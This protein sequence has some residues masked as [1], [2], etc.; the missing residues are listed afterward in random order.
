M[1]R[2]IIRD[3]FV[4]SKKSKNATKDDLP[5]AID[6]RDTLLANKTRAL[7]IAANMIGVNKNI[8]AFFIGPLPIVM[9]NPVI[10]KKKEKYLAKEGCLPLIG[11]RN[12]ERFKK[13]LVKYEDINFEEKVAEYEDETAEV[14]Q[15]EVDHC[16]G[17]II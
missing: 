7:G 9:I 17:K 5:L 14:I 6:L 13:I 11:E 4:L 10:L 16:K 8:I 3:Q 2:K 15:H 1:E 12:V